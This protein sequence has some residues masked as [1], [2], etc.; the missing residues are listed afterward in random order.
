MGNG[1]R[2]FWCGGALVSPTH[3]VTAAHCTLDAKKRPFRP[4][5][6]K[7]RVGEWDLG[8]RD[9]YSREY[10][11]RHIVSYPQFRPNGFYNDVAVFT[12]EQPVAFNE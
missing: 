7:I 2:E 1:K 12:L 4:T 8:D 9:T 11:V 10:R 3:V 6:F 5:Q